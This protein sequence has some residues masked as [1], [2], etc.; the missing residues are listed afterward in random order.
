MN[1]IVHNGDLYLLANIS[2][3]KPPELNHVMV[4]KFMQPRSGR[5]VRDF[6]SQLASYHLLRQFSTSFCCFSQLRAFSDG[7]LSLKVN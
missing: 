2:N 4:K 6:H 1:L 7:I 3:M 5:F